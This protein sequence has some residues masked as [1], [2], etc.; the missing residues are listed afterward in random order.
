V[1]AKAPA[2]LSRLQR[3][4]L[5]AMLRYVE[6]AEQHQGRD[7][8]GRHPIPVKWPRKDGHYKTRADSAAFSRAL[9]RLETR[10]LALR[11]N[12]SSGMP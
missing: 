1:S 11:S 3:R 10:A 9:R 12:V 8:R 7:I 5:A 6:W 4:I 2:K